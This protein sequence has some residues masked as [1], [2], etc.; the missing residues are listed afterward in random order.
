MDFIGYLKKYFLYFHI[1]L[2]PENEVSE[3]D[4]F[5]MLLAQEI[6]DL[7]LSDNEKVN[8]TSFQDIGL[9]DLV[10]VNVT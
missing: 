10:G 4:I 2:V 6:C 1:F 3:L 7:S 5:K 9:G 8:L